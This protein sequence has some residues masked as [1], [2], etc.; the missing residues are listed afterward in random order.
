[1]V[2]LLSTTDHIQLWSIVISMHRMSKLSWTDV[3]AGRATALHRKH[4]HI[5]SYTFCVTWKRKAEKRQFIRSLFS[6]P[7]T[8]LP[9]WPSLAV[10]R[11]FI[12][13]CRSD[14][15]GPFLGQWA[16]C[17]TELETERGGR[18]FQTLT[19]THYI[20]TPSFKYWDMLYTLTKL[21]EPSQN[22]VNVSTVQH[23]PFSDHKLCTSELHS[24]SAVAVGRL[25]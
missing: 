23:L 22:T 13:S 7:P 5:A 12:Q 4:Q 3:Q 20:V 8:P 21:Q 17:C 1:M 10:L 18:S 6:V 19:H 11:W 16:P 9:A 24:H 25:S 15:C 14:E 2:Y